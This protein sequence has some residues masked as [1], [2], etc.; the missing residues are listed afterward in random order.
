MKTIEKPLGFEWDEGNRE[1]S[2]IKHKISAQEAQQV[3]FDEHKIVYKDV[4][5]SVAEDRYIVLGQTESAQIL[6]VVYTL[7]GEKVRIISARPA[8]RKEV[9]L[10]EKEN[11]AAKV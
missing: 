11:S 8:N 7:R 9:L 5:H 6:F 1:K 2:W 4:P 3:F 10:Y